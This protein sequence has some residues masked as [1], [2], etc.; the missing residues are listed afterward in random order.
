MFT[1]DYVHVLTSLPSKQRVVQSSVEDNFAWIAWEFVK[2]NNHSY[3]KDVT[4]HGL[5]R[6]SLHEQ[7][8]IEI[9]HL[10]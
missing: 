2:V 1:H 3:R 6:C 5:K 7:L 9:H 10:L 4:M 8:Q